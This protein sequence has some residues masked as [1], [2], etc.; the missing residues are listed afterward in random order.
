M[1][2]HHKHFEVE[3]TRKQPHADTWG[4]VQLQ[5]YRTVNFFKLPELTNMLQTQYLTNMK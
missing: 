2:L 4:F 5:S 3:G 1:S